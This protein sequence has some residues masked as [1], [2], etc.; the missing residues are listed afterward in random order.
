[1]V[2]IQFCILPRFI[3]AA[4]RKPT[5][6]TDLSCS[7][8]CAASER[9]SGS[10]SRILCRLK[11]STPRMAPRSMAGS[12]PPSALSC[13][14]RICTLP[15]MALMRCSTARSSSSDTRSVLLSRTRSAKAICSTDSF[16]TPSGFCSSRC[17]VMCL[18]STTV[19]TASILANARTPSSTKNVWQTGAGSAMPVVSTMIRS[20]RSCR[21][22]SFLKISIRSPRT[23]QHTQPF[24]MSNTTSLSLK[25]AFRVLINAS[26]TPTSPN[27]FSMTA[28]FLP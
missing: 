12:R 1:M 28:I 17:W 14:R 25:L 2:R 7:C 20:N 15:L 3:S 5:L 21:F 22:W 27:S 8:A 23:V 11:A 26:S 19:M 24:A 6:P 9:K 18:A 16:S 13:V 10:A 4:N